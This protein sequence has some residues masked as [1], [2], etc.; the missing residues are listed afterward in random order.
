MFDRLNGTDVVI[1]AN[2]GE[3]LRQMRAHGNLTL[4][5]DQ[6]CL[7]QA[8]TTELNSQVRRMYAIYQAAH[9]VAIWLGVGDARSD[10]T[11]LEIQRASDE[12]GEPAGIFE[13]SILGFEYWQR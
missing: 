5:V 8:R 13:G 7:N 2:P 6:L 10:Q 1:T 4:W 12:G 11:I 3:G 9:E